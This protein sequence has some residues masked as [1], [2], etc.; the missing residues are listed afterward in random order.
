MIAHTSLDY[1]RYWFHW[2]M[3]TIVV[4]VYR[5]ALANC[6]MDPHKCDGQGLYIGDEKYDLQLPKS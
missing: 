4:I 1:L 5:K 2:F 6:S 3:V